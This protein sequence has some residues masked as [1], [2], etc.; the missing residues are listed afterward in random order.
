M[1]DDTP[2][3]E[4]SY[5]ERELRMAVEDDVL[6]TPSLVAG[7]LDCVCVDARRAIYVYRIDLSEADAATCL[8]T[9]MGGNDRQ[10]TTARYRLRELALEWMRE[11][12]ETRVADLMREQ[13]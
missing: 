5:T 8:A 9:I 2:L 13:E 10:A 3:R 1:D 7:W 6:T 4:R 12:V 11:D